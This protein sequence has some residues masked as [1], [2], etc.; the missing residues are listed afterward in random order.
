MNIRIFPFLFLL[1]TS[2]FWGWAYTYP[3]VKGSDINGD[4]KI[5]CIDY[6]IS[7]KL[8]WDQYNSGSEYRCEIVHNRN[9]HTGMD[10][11]FIRVRNKDHNW[12]YIEPQNGL[13]MEDYW[14]DKY[15]PAYN[16]FGE[17]DYWLSKRN[18]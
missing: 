5:N 17:T 15:N 6:A 3:K 16:I 7:Y 9:P 4:G 18:F 2:S 13:D 12:E 8:I 1:L 14:G 10:H 11:L